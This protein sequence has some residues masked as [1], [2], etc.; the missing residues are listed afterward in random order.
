MNHK[1]VGSLIAVPVA[2]D[3]HVQAAVLGRRLAL[4]AAGLVIDVVAALKLQ[5]TN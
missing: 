4:L 5:R 2:G 3:V 1:L